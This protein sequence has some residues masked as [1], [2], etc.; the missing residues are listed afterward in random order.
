MDVKAVLLDIQGVLLQDGVGIDDAAA[1]VEWLRDRKLPIRFL[2]N[3][4]TQPHR[5]IAEKLG[6]GGIP[7]TPEEVF[8]PPIAAAAVL[9]KHGCRT[10]HLAANAALAEDLS[11]FEQTD[12]K[13]D[14]IVLGDLHRGFDWDRLDGLFRMLRDGALL[15]ALHKNRYCR[16][17]DEI[18]LDLGP[19]VAALEY[20]AD[21][22]A[23]VVGKPAAEFF[24]MAL[25]DL[26]VSASE[27]LMIGDDLEADVAGAQRAGIRAYQVRTGKFRPE[28]EQHASIQPEA[29]LD[30]IADLPAHLAR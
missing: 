5:A 13:P 29:R 8:S 15:I 25:A 7:A 14:A 30:S 27:A 6:D 12:S 21:C 19:F 4:T 11:D 20:A 1:T 9:R 16:R 10:I 28:D 18:V 3:V 2:T 17:G 26:G 23:I 22:E 24:A